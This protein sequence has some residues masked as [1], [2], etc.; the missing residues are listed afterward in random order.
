MREL[1]CCLFVLLLCCVIVAA[2]EPKDD[3]VRTAAAESDEAWL[4]AVERLRSM[5]RPGEFKHGRLAVHVAEM[6]DLTPQQKNEL[7]KL[8]SNYEAERLKLAA[9]WLD[10]LK[11]L[12]AKFE[13]GVAQH[14]PAA[15]RE[16]LSKALEYSHANFV[17]PIDREFDFKRQYAER[18]GKLLDARAKASVE[19]LEEMREE[20]QAWVKQPRQKINQQDQQTVNAVKAMLNPDE[21]AH[22]EAKK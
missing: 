4:A 8:E 20:M 1:K 10:E 12:R 2:Q 19:Q 13:P 5:P 22:L 21:A 3:V 6:A 18:A 14:L 9:K 15:R 7:Q 11:A 16:A 17:T